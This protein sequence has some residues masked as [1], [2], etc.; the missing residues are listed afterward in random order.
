MA[1]SLL[2][3]GVIAAIAAILLSPVFGYS[4]SAGYHLRSGSLTSK[5]KAALLKLAKIGAAGAI[6]AYT[7]PIIIAMSPL[8]IGTAVIGGVVLVLHYDIPH[9]R[10]L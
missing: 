8:L 5:E 3:T 9:W 10:I 7:A 6:A 2:V 1:I 4:T